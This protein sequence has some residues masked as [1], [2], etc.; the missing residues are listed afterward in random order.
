MYNSLKDC[1][2]DAFFVVFG[3]FT[4]HRNI[5]VCLV[6]NKSEKHYKGDRKE[7][8]NKFLNALTQAFWGPNGL[9]SESRIGSKRFWGLLMLMSN[10]YFLSFLSYVF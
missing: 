5:L 1:N 9:F 10:F 7:L 4:L 3:V 2:S 6:I 8:D